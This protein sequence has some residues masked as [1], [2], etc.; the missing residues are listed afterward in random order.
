M[1][2][3]FMANK[4]I[5]VYRRQLA[6]QSAKALDDTKLYMQ[7][8][9]TLAHFLYSILNEFVTIPCTKIK[10]ITY[11]VCKSK[12]TIP[13][14]INFSKFLEYILNI[15]IDTNPSYYESLSMTSLFYNNIIENNVVWAFIEKFFPNVKTIN[16]SV[17]SK[18]S[19]YKVFEF[20]KPHLLAVE[21][22]NTVNPQ[23]HPTYY[24]QAYQNGNNPK[25]HIPLE[26]FNKPP[27]YHFIKNAKHVSKYI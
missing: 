10:C 20:N 13:H 24:S 9:S 16:Y 18:Y 2:N 15:I 3:T 6:E 17:V 8:L 19:P 12:T 7:D 14:C 21:S 27:E 1:D 26:S 22:Y 23:H 11:P 5:D 4:A 25:K